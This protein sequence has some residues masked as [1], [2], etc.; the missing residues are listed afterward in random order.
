[1]SLAF[2]YSD[3]ERGGRSQWKKENRRMRLGQDQE[4]AVVCVMATIGLLCDGCGAYL[5]G[6]STHYGHCAAT[7]CKSK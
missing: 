7:L 3:V 2:S 5:V 6:Y 1:M 4:E